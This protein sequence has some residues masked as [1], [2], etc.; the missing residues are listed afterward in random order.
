[1]KHKWPIAKIRKEDNLIAIWFTHEYWLL[2]QYPVVNQ[3]LNRREMLGS[4]R[5][6]TEERGALGKTWR[7]N[8]RLKNWETVDSWPS[9]STEVETAMEFF[10]VGYKAWGHINSDDP[11]K[12]TPAKLQSRGDQSEKKGYD[13]ET[14]LIEEGKLHEQTT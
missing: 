4:Y 10:T 5:R 2:L 13:E 9:Y 11:H 7:S 14:K 1:M 12:W 8:K 6:R 3:Y